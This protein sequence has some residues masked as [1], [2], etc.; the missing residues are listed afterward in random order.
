MMKESSLIHVALI[1]FSF[2]ALSLIPTACVNSRREVN[3]N[4]RPKMIAIMITINTGVGIGIPGIKLPHALM[5][6][7]STDGVAPPLIQ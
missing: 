1:P 4:S 2:A 7:L 5:M 3:L 6:G